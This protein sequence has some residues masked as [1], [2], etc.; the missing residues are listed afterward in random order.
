M[1]RTICLA[2]LLMCTS[3][4]SAAPEYRV[5]STAVLGGEGSWDYLSIDSAAH[6]LYIGRSDRVMAVDTATGK[7]A[8]EITGLAGVH[9]LAVAGDTGRGYVSCGKGNT[10]RVI[11]L[12]T[13][14]E[15]ASLAAGKKPD[16]II[17]DPA[18]K[19]VLAFNNGGTTATVVDPVKNAV[20]GEIELGGAPEFAVADG[21]G[22]VFVNLEDKSEVLELD[23]PGRKV[24]NRWPLA[25]GTA[26]TGLAMDVEHGRLF[27]ACHDSKTMVVLDAGS[28]KILASLPIG[29]GTD[30]AAFDPDS[31]NAFSSNG[32]G[33]LTVVHEDSPDKFTVTQTLKTMPSARTMTLDP[34]TH[35]IWLVAGTGRNGPKQEF[36]LICVSK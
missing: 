31:Q 7:L 28:G 10:V 24:V 29:D 19:M 35:K 6:R 20:A 15:S 22:K 26:P 1:I 5:E 33:T 2:S 4:F 32:D 17:Y 18:S 3:V 11:D 34:K 8:G 13:L 14:K 16:A 9:G 12:T 23:I 25:P 21:K 36:T 30:A 27:S